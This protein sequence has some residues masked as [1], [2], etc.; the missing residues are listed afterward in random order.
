MIKLNLIK[1]NKSINKAYLKIKPVR[2]EFENFKNQL[3]E[4][5]KL[6]NKK[7][8]EEHNKNL[9]RDFL[10]N[11][12]YSDKYVN[13]KGKTDLAI[14]LGKK[15]ES[16]VGVIIEAKRP[17]EKKDM[18]S[19]NN[20]NC[21]AMHEVIL[22]YLRERIENSNDEIKNI[23]ITNA[24]KWFIF[25]AE[26]F[27]KLFYKSKLRN[28]YE[29]WRDDKKV[30]KL[31]DHFYNEIVK[32][33]LDETDAEL[34]VVSFDLR[35]FEKYL[36]ERNE[37]KLIP[38][39]KKFSPPELLKEPFA[40]DSNTLNKQ[41]YSELLHIIGLEE[42]KEGSKKKIGR[43]AENK[44]DNGSLLENT[45]RML[46]VKNIFQNLDDITTYGTTEDEQ[47]YN[48]ALELN[49]VWINRI[50]FLKLLEAQLVNYHSGDENYKFLD[51]KIISQYDD[52]FELFHEVLAVKS[53]ERNPDLIGKFS[54]IPYLNSSLFELSDLEKNT[55]D[56][57]GLKDRFNL[58][59]YKN[60]VFG[61]KIKAK[62]ELPT[63]KYLLMFLDA[64]D[65]ASESG[66]EILEEHKTIINA[67]VL[68]LIFEKINGYKEGS[69][70]TPGFI[71]MYMAR[72]TLRRAVV[73]KF[74][75]AKGTEYKDY[76]ELTKNLDISYEGRIEA[77]KIINDLKICD[78]SVGSGHFL[79]S[80]LNEI[81]AIKAD[82]KIFDFRNGKQVQNY[83]F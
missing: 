77:N 63:L 50:L 49:I 12:F 73:Q 64:F 82:L 39:F 65:F 52:L 2:T 33:F 26:Q 75:E 70:Y 62:G 54:K 81:I 48:I 28:E 56:I 53:S 15:S 37:K 55:I 67:S 3:S 18:I 14:H 58:P 34:D 76:E 57:S 13:T 31:N 8:G 16:F 32:R 74:N 35:E 60:T 69:F 51:P 68:G 46:K 29:K 45:I 43:K 22:Y 80:C 10:I 78:P 25:K 40:N 36:N 83:S 30:N 6:I 41:F 66:E 7:E 24:F 21:K 4:L 72:E 27:E 11:T 5:L 1:I 9:I 44:R 42:Y 23:I 79:V 17:S 47:I 38:L 71:T 61:K 20:L 19:E 59:F